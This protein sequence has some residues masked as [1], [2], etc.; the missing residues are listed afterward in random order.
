MRQMSVCTL[1]SPGES[2]LK[3][4]SFLLRILKHL[5]FATKLSWVTN[6]APVTWINEI[7]VMPINDFIACD[8]S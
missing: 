2:C 3:M 8:Y 4:T 7:P 1:P 6:K 5:Y